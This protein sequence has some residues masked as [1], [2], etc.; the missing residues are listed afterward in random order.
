MKPDGA[1]RGL[2]SLPEPPGP[3]IGDGQLVED[4]LVIRI[5]RRRL[6][7]F[8]HRQV[9]LALRHH[10]VGLSHEAIGFDHVLLRNRQLLD[11]GQAA[12]RGVIRPKR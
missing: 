3:A 2:P 9:V 8:Q 11:A 4:G 10:L 5:Q 12:F 1:L 6:D 7:V